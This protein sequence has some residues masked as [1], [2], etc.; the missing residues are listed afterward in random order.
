[1]EDALLW[2]H[3]GPPLTVAASPLTSPWFALSSSQ[4]GADSISQAV[5]WWA[6]AGGT[7]TVSVQGS[8][9]G[10]NADADF[11]YTVTTGTPF[12]IISPYFRVSVAQTVADATKTKLTVIGR[13]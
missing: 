4:L 6:A 13:T 2:A 5:V 9:D 1:M 3:N 12:S 7:T 10:Q 8:W 11:A